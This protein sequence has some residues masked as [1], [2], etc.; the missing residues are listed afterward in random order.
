MTYGL[1]VLL[2]SFL[3]GTS[4]DQ[5][6]AADPATITLDGGPVLPLAA[7]AQRR[8]L[9]GSVPLYSVAIYSDVPLRDV[10]LSSP[11]TPKAALIRVTFEPDLKRRVTLDWRGELI[12]PL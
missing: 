4:P 7:Q 2:F 10:S 5:A 3:V 1:A 6:P 11:A 9:L 8:H 12:P